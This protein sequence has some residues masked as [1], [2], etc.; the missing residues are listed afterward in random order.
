MEQRVAV[1]G[2]GYAGLAAALA[3]VESG[4]PVT[5][6]ESSKS[7]G[8]RARG[9]A[10]KGTRLDNG[11][12]ILLGCYR[13]TIALIE[14]VCRI[15]EPLLRMPLELSVDE[16]RLKSLPLPPPLDLVFGLLWAKG[17]SFPERLNALGFLSKAMRMKL[18]ADIP[19]SALL[20]EEKQQGRLTDFLWKP[21][22]IA[23]LNTPVE[24]A[25]AKV[26]LAVLQDGLNG[27]GSDILIPRVDL[28]ALF[29]SGAAAII[30]ERGGEI[31]LS[32]PAR[33]LR[34][35]G[36]GFELSTDTGTRSFSHVICA[37]APQHAS[38]LT[39]EIP[40][41]R[42]PDF[43]YQPICTVYSQYPE[44]IRLPGKMTGFS[45]G[46]T[47]WLFDKG[48]ISGQ[49]G[50]I[51]AVISAARMKLDHGAIAAKVHEE[52]K[53]L[54]PELPPPLWQKVI[55]EKRATFSC[56]VNQQRPGCETP[57]P[58]LFI[59]GDYTAAHYPATLEAAVRSGLEC[60]A[61]TLK[62]I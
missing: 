34:R 44:Y 35:C 30:A 41:I 55:L 6:F 5:L 21:L 22:C 54:M 50:L 36:S 14:R 60:A 29:P 27:R 47:H 62:T 33:S 37:A 46:L 18:D 25:S 26:F 53:G 2:G 32:S 4:A 58:R 51:A 23:A 24:E 45:N 56:R 48:A 1:I 49:P 15:P 8:G 40:E 39:R 57:V 3:L 52:T 59:A 19:V 43:D 12:H 10:W 31:R 17:I 38:D 28:T 42:L 9:I 20:C 13:E 11:Q 7:L 61:N 16:F